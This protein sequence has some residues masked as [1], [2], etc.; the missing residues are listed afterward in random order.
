M[1]SSPQAPTITIGAMGGIEMK[2]LLLASACVAAQ[3]LVVA[4]AAAQSG[5][6]ANPNEDQDRG[7]AVEDVIVTA[8]RRAERV[9]DVPVSVTTLSQDDLNER[10]I[11]NYDGLATPRRA[12]C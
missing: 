8:T 2:A 3:L 6:S 4:P 10:G 12:S 1:S 5:Q 7:A 11:V 9:Q